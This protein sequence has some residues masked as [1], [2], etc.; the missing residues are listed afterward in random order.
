MVEHFLSLLEFR[1]LDE[2]YPEGLLS[3]AMEDL[4]RDYGVIG[5]LLLGEVEHLDLHADCVGY[6]AE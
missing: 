4:L 5:C 1:L 3:F 6:L 2:L